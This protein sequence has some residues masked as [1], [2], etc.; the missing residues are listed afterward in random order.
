MLN[1]AHNS[2]GP[3]TCVG[4]EMG[5]EALTAAEVEKDAVGALFD[6]IFAIKN[7]E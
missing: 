4:I 7:V 2:V 1:S 6:Q 3:Q 5:R